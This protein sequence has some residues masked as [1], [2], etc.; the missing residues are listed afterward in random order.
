MHFRIKRIENLMRDNSVF[1][2][3][4]GIINEK[5]CGK[6]SK[7]DVYFQDNKERKSTFEKT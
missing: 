1:D 3:P 5:I 7:K 4:G 6:F 2:E